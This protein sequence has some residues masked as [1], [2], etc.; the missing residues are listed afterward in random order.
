VVVVRG[1]GP[2]PAVMEGVAFEE[3]MTD[4]SIFFF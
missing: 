2:W 4:M 1:S 3:D